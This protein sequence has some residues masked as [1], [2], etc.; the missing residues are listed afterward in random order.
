MC[1]RDRGLPCQSYICV[2][3]LA[4][5]TRG[6]PH[7]RSP[8]VNLWASHAAQ[9]TEAREGPPVGLRSETQSR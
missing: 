2:L 3:R 8:S 6:F 4:L 5:R 9:T 7:S 1:I